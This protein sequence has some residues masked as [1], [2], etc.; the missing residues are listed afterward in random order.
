LA[1]LYGLITEE[2]NEKIEADAYELVKQLS[3]FRYSLKTN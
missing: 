3:T 1:L 2:V